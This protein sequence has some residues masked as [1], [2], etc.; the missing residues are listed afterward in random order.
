MLG[1]TVICHFPWCRFCPKRAGY[2][3]GRKISKTVIFFWE[4]I[5]ISSFTIWRKVK[6]SHITSN[7]EDLHFSLQ[8]NRCKKI[9]EFSVRN[10]GKLCHVMSLLAEILKQIVFFA[11]NF[12]S[13]L[14]L[15]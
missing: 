7:G 12:Y 4:I 5:Q 8:T 10:S 6:I 1:H 14:S 13:R 3:F 2:Y 15:K 11:Q 9:L